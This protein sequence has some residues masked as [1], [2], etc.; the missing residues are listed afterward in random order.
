VN[1]IVLDEDSAPEQR[2]AAMR[3]RTY[4]TFA[5]LL[6]YPDQELGEAIRSGTVAETLR[7]VLG[8][9][10]PLLLES[11]DWEALSNAGEGDDL[12]VE[13]TR[14]FDVGAAGPPCPLYGGLYGD[15]R[16]KTMEE[17]VRFYNYFG[18]T[19][20]EKPRE[21]PD[22][23]TTQLEFLH[24][25]TFREAEAIAQSEDP[26]PYRRAQ[27]D[28]AM[29]HPGRWVPKLRERLERENPMPFFAELVRRL[30]RFLDRD[31]ARLVSLVGPPAAGKTP[32]TPR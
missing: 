17:A 25:L 31:C 19:L 5:Q 10:D 15:A 9:I 21:L 2:L 13:F 4:A 28:F 8:A 27:R 18:L 14:L 24:F 1:E 12:E 7:E 22:H 32:A 30:E 23:I 26:D 29:R 3:S 20:S 16:M 6:E 11:A